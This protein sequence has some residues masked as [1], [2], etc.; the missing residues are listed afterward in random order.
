MLGAAVA[1]GESDL[2]KR[3]F[4]INQPLFCFFN[5]LQNKK[6]FNGYSFHF[7]KKAADGRLIFVNIIAH[8]FRHT[9]MFFDASTLYFLNEQGFYFFNQLRFLVVEEFKTCCF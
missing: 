7:R 1:K 4:I 9:E 8:V 3:L 6:L 5:F 2:T